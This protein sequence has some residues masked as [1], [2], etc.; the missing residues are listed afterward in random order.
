M[1]YLNIIKQCTL[2]LLVAVTVASCDKVK[3]TEP[4]GD[5]GSLLV[6]L[7][8]GGT[9][10]APGL[11]KN[12]I[13][14]LPTPIT[15][16]GA[17][18]Q[19]LVPSNAVLNT[20]MHVTVKDDTAAVRTAGLTLLPASW[21]T[22]GSTTPKTGGDGGIFNITIP[23]GEFA[24]PILITIPDATK[25]DPST[26]YGLGFTI[27]SVDAGGKISVTNTTVFQ[28]GAKNAYDGVYSVV[29]GTVTRYSA[30]GAP[31]GDALSGSLA[32][33]DDVTMAT[34]GAYTVNMTNLG[35]HD[36]ASNGGV[37]GVDPIYVTV[38]PATNLTNTTSVGNPSM[39]NWAGH[40]NKYDPAS[41]TFYLAM[42]WNPATTV[43]EYEIVLKYKKAR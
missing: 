25:L 36:K 29:S 15:V 40:V 39:T 12:A 42:R 33:N 26:Q 37:G 13:D 7:V 34:T 21:Y 35:W 43:R 6:K 22:I 18:L 27:T 3:V 11:L 14:F 28:L 5:N 32:G 16:M 24:R 30:P 31:L 4:M 1:K 9:T 38:D 23:A 8:G 19:R 2:L 17:D 41:K 20:V 10:A